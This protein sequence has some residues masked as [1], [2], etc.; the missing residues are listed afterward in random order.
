MPYE[1]IAYTADKR[2]VKGTLAVT[3][4][5]LAE[6][7][8]QK[9]GYCVISLSQ[10][11]PRPTL[12]Q[13]MPTFFGVK[14]KAVVTFLR[15]LATLLESGIILTS[16]VR[17]LEEQTN[18]APLKKVIADLSVDL[19]EGNSFSQALAKFPNVFPRICFQTVAAGQQTGNLDL[20]LR[21]AVMYMERDMTAKQKIQRALAY[22]ALVLALAVGV[23]AILINVALP[24]LLALFSGL[25][26]DL[27]WTTKILLSVSSFLLDYK[28]YILGV[29]IAIIIFVT[30]FIRR[31]SGRLV[32]D[33]LLLK[34]PGIGGVIYMRNMAFFARNVSIMLKAGLSIMQIMDT[35][36]QTTG[37]LVMRQALIDL[38]QRIVQGQGLSK[39]MAANKLF[40]NLLVE[41]ATTGEQSGNLDSILATLADYYEDE[42][43]QRVN[44]LVAMLEPAMTVLIG[45]VVALI[46]LSL[47]MPLYGI[48][49][50]I[51]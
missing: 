15:N 39:S 51:G 31:P 21:Q 50:H 22:P 33:K 40:P 2:I 30:L 9:A 1:Y 20:A 47:I 13:I 12:A 46:A 42:A 41:G 17:L 14:P 7:A 11:R 28:F 38:Q 25:G 44:S 5:S 49:S 4:E 19:Q 45:M 43:N 36:Y 29:I 8:L 35:V 34:I 16:A 32:W 6:E 37:N 10:V 27:P 26:V 3:I 23:V 18:S 24:P 48:M